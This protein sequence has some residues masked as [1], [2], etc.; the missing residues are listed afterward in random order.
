L[1]GEL[2]IFQ[3]KHA[4]PDGQTGVHWQQTPG[5]PSRFVTPSAP[6]VPENL[7]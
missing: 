3:I 1:R 7:C 4:K 2:R 5:M 6:R